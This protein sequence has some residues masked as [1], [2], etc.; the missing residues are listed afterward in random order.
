[1]IYHELIDKSSGMVDEP[2][3]NISMEVDQVNETAGSGMFD[4][5]GRDV[6]LGQGGRIG[7]AIIHDL[8]PITTNA[9]VASGQ[10]IGGT[11]F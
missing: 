3:A 5:V 10:S 4:L 2:E 1:M 7:N 11:D 9:C 8:D 6:V